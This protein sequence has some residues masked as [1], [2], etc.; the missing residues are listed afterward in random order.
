MGGGG[1]QGL[2]KFTSQWTWKSKNHLHLNNNHV[3]EKVYKRD[4]KDNGAECA[5]IDPRDTKTPTLD[6]W[7]WKTI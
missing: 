2:V 3:F 1:L 4:I 7:K 6:V 5:K